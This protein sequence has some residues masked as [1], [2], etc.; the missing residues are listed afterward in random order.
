MNQN[1]KVE[2]REG[3]EWLF[4]IQARMSCPEQEEEMHTQASSSSQSHVR[5]LVSSLVSPCEMQ[6]FLGG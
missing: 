2:E 6:T 1:V 5:S 4:V 3:G